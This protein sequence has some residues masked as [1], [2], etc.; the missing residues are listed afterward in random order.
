MHKILIV[1]DEEDILENIETRLKM[2]GY[3][4]LTATNG[5]D[6]INLALNESPD[7]ILLDLT[8]PKVSGMEVCKQLKARLSTFVP[9]IMVSGKSEL[10]D[11]IAGLDQGA[12]DY[13]TKPFHMD[14]LLARVRAILRNKQILDDM[15]KT[16]VTDSLT[17]IYNRRYFLVRLEEECGRA[18]RR[19]RAFSCMMLALNGYR[20]AGERCG[21]DFMEE[22]LK[23]TV[24]RLRPL[25]QE[26]DV[27]I[28]FGEEKFVVIMPETGAEGAQDLA[29]RAREAV[30]AEPFGDAA[31]TIALG[32]RVGTCSFPSDRI[33]NMNQMTEYIEF[34]LLGHSSHDP[35]PEE[36]GAEP[37]ENLEPETP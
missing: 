13:L 33:E 16:T 1:D 27:F 9:I 3:G 25:L 34:F 26:S 20:D 15:K 18:Q 29:K 30:R 24:S 21:Q 31:Q 4:T 11:K 37:A 5:A 6:A 12:D 32:C 23:Q 36:A 2:S 14:E 7:L 17:G 10:E 22:I 28:R 8:L 19:G 35:G